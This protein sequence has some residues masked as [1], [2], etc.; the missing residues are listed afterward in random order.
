M[1]LVREPGAI[2]HSTGAAA[3]S[4]NATAQHERERSRL[5]GREWPNQSGTARRLDGR[6]ITR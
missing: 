5:A 4:K 1:G 6:S 2:A 3:E